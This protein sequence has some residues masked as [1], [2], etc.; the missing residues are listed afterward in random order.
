MCRA[1]S[2]P[3]GGRR[4]PLTE[5][6]REAGKA[7]A[8]RYY[9]R[10]KARLLIAQLADH[11]I[12]A[13]DDGGMPPTYHLAHTGEMVDLEEER[14]DIQNWAIGS[15]GTPGKPT[16]ALWSSP[17]RVDNSGNVK[18]AWTDW[19]ARQGYADENDTGGKEVKGALTRLQ[20]QP[21]AVVAVVSSPDDALHLSERYG[22]EETNGEQHLDWE[23]M[24]RDG[25]DGVCVTDSFSQEAKKAD[26]GHPAS[27]FSGWDAGSTAWLST[28]RLEASGKGRP[29][30]YDDDDDGL[31]EDAYSEPQTPEIEGAWERVPKKVRESKAAETGL[32]PGTGAG[33]TPLTHTPPG[34]GEEAPASRRPGQVK[35]PKPK[36]Y[37]ETVPREQ[38]G[39][40]DV[41][42]DAIEFLRV[43]LDE[44]KSK[45]EA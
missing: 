18:T 41:G 20:A 30:V 7:A 19:S 27:Q 15:G 40:L 42:K 9:K 33:L 44:D 8:T 3:S 35:A 24:R 17:G 6:S 21:G 43:V 13:T 10:G 38:G 32:A 14:G 1:C 36:E 37:T 29:G 23:A 12:R 22:L 11:G 4:C 2:D 39:Y 45:K 28:E 31:R 34:A 25:V 16:G 5:D 26:R